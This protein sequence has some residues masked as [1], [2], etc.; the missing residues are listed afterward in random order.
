[1]TNYWLQKRRIMKAKE[2]TLKVT[3]EAITQ[4]ICNFPNS[5]GLEYWITNVF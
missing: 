4:L 1:M 5:Y 2:L 3:R